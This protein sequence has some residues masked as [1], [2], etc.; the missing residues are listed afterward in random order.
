MAMNT[1]FCKRFRSRN[2]E[3]HG[4]YEAPC[5]STPESANLRSTLDLYTSDFGSEP[6]DFTIPAA[7]GRPQL[8]PL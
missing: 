8:R 3:R 6:K 5:A 4:A 2:L 1:T 7:G